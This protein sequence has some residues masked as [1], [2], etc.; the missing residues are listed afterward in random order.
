MEV[1]SRFRSVAVV[2]AEEG[3]VVG[4]RPMRLISPRG[5]SVEGLDAQTLAYLL[6]VIG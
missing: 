5:Y 2:P 4:E 3:T 1:S 6:Q